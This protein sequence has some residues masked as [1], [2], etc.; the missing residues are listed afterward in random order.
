MRKLENSGFSFLKLKWFKKKRARHFH[1][2]LVRSGGFVDPSVGIH[3]SRS[4]NILEDRT[5]PDAG[6]I[7]GKST[8]KPVRVLSRCIRNTV[9]AGETCLKQQ[10]H[11]L[12]R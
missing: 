2:F 6:L 3:A 9:E 1:N 11:N 12:Y 5:L 7:N 10:T 4:A 8:R